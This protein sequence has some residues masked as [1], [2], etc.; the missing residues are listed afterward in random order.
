MKVK[1]QKQFP[2]I[3]VAGTKNRVFI[4]PIMPDEDEKVLSSGLIIPKAAHVK[5]FT[6]QEPNAS[7]EPKKLP[8]EGIIIAIS[9]RDEVGQTPNTEV[10]DHVFFDPFA[11]KEQAYG[12]ETYLFLR[13]GSIHAK[14]AK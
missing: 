9:E 14:L 11:A 2:L 8:T 5:A 3:P 4:K 13:E 10:G 12:T 7:E 1:E 6:R